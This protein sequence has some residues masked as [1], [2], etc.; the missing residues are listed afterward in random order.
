GRRSIAGDRRYV[1][2]TDSTALLAGLVYCA[3]CGSKMHYGTNPRN[4][5]NWRAFRCRR[6]IDGGRDACSAR[7]ALAGPL[8]AQVLGM[9]GVLSLALDGDWLDEALQIAEAALATP[10]TQP[11]TIDPA[12]IHEKIRRLGRLYEDGLKSDADYR[13]E[14]AA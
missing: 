6:K 7:Y 5:P 4:R 11:L 10:R 2:T 9:L 8:E 12:K 14:L 3:E 1:R 13:S